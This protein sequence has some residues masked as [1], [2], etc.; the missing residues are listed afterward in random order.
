[1]FHTLVFVLEEAGKSIRRN[2]LMS[3]AALSTVTVALMVF[4]GSLF[5]LYRL[6]QFVASQ[7]G[8]FRISVFLHVDQS[9][10]ATLELARRMRG[11]PGVES[12]SVVT[13][14]QA[15]ADLRRKDERRQTSI[16]A[17]LGNVNPLPDRIDIRVSPPERSSAVADSLRDSKRF[18]QIEAVR[19]ERALL[20]QLLATSRL[21]RNVGGSIAVLLF[22]ATG[23]VIQNTLRLTIFARRR[24]IAIMR[25]V[26]ATRALIRGP[27]VAEG[28]FYGVLGALLAGIALASVLTQSSRY[29]AR[30]QTPLAQGIPPGPS[31]PLMMGSLLAVGLIL[32]A[33]TSW[34]AIRRFLR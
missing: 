24:E 4:G 20:E 11:L 6:H 22:L 2:G 28:V 9:R 7:P 13:K 12:V 26:G 1:M 8:R 3:F 27:L 34:M 25:L 21:V 14:E 15:L 31:V 18:P 16:A 33:V 5:G 17:A 30:Y 29:L 23:V 10:A 32:G 19:D